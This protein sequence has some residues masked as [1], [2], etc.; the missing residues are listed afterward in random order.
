MNGGLD[1]D[2]ITDAM[3]AG[4]RMMIEREVSPLLL[5]LAVLEAKVDLLVGTEPAKI[6]PKRARRKP[7]P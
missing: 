6:D 3:I 1:W 5:R 7:L 2:K 4:C